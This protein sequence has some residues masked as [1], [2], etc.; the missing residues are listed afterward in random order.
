[1]CVYFFLC[2][3]LNQ[4]KKNEFNILIYMHEYLKGQIKSCCIFHENVEHVSTYI[5]GT[6][7]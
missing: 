3:L 7:N 5:L 6:N 2:M 1:V 4:K